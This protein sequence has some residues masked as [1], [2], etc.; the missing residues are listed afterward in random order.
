MSSA[1]VQ[2]IDWQIPVDIEI[3][4]GQFHQDKEHQKLWDELYKKVLKVKRGVRNTDSL[5]AYQTGLSG[6]LTTVSSN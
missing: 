3:I 2:V 6:N 4:R 5:S 1:A